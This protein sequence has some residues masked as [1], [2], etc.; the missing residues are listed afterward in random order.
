MLSMINVLSGMSASL[1]GRFGSSAFR[2]STNCSVDVAHGLVLLFGIGTRALP[3]CRL[4]YSCTEP[5]VHRVGQH[6][7]EQ[8]EAGVHPHAGIAKVPVD[9]HGHGLATPNPFLA[10]ACARTAQRRPANSSYDAQYEN[11]LFF[12][13]LRA[14]AVVCCKTLNP[15]ISQLRQQT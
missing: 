5:P 2:L 4:S 3:S 10:R 11:K 15:A 7:G 14:T 1:I 12:C 8:V 13:S 9:A 6:G